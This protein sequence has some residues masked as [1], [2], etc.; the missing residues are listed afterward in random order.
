MVTSDL[1]FDAE[2]FP[3][4]LVAIAAMRRSAGEALHGVVDHDLEQSRGG[5]ASLSR[6]HRFQEIGLFGAGHL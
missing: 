2:H 5:L 4:N 3:A 1:V 6:L